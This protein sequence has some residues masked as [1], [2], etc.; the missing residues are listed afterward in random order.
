MDVQIPEMDGFEATQK[1]REKEREPGERI[2]IIAMA[3]HALKGDEERCVK[4]GM[5]GYVS[6]P[7]RTNDEAG[8]RA[9]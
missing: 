7:I 3:A 2:P 9:K 1:I 6:K 8:S 4:A 5:G